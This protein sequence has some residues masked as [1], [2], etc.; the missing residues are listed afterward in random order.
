MQCINLSIYQ[1]RTHHLGEFI[2]IFDSAGPL[3]ELFAQLKRTRSNWHTR[4]HY[5]DILYKKLLLFPVL[6]STVMFRWWH[7]AA[8]DTDGFYLT[9]R[10]TH[11]S[12]TQVICCW[13]KTFPGLW[14]CG[15]VAEELGANLHQLKTDP[16]AT[17]RRPER[18]LQTCQQKRVMIFSETLLAE[19][20]IGFMS[21]SCRSDA[22][23][24]WRSPRWDA[25]FLPSNVKQFMAL[26][27]PTI[28][29]VSSFVI[30]RPAKISSLV[31]PPKLPC[32]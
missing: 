17:K 22:G 31:K 12:G 1:Q 28:L 11:F 27:I 23:T 6:L 32:F 19:F 26:D 2:L 15:P 25:Q 20:H 7:F 14:V 13:R 29:G 18:S 21:T 9:H 8:Y 30:S 16:K 4:H 24:N 5:I 10:F 3:Q